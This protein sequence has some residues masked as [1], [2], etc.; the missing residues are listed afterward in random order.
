MTGDKDQVMIH[1]TFKKESRRLTESKNAQSFSEKMALN[2]FKINFSTVFVPVC[3]PPVWCLC[4]G[5]IL[6]YQVLR[7]IRG[8]KSRINN[9][10]RIPTLAMELV[11]F[12]L[13]A[14]SVQPHSVFM[15]MLNLIFGCHGGVCRHSS[16][17]LTK[18]FS[19]F[20]VL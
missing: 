18:Y 16:L 5:Y 7:L 11:N 20:V 2:T 4:L 19:A 17:L 15:C 3:V 13:P 8:K 12:G 14:V 9:K 10:I 6:I 1:D